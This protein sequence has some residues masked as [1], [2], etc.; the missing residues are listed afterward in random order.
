[1]ERIIIEGKGYVPIKAI[2]GLCCRVAFYTGL[3]FGMGGVAIVPWLAKTSLWHGIQAEKMADSM[4]DQAARCEVRMMA[5]E[6]SCPMQA[7]LRSA[8]RNIGGE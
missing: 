7:R 3:G 8:T 1:M 6:K 2:V 5:A 4:L